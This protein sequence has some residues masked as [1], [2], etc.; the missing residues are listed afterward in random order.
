MIGL[1][2]VPVRRLGS[3]HLAVLQRSGSM[4]LVRGNDLRAD[5]CGLGEAFGH[6][7]AQ[8]VDLLECAMHI[9]KQRRHRQNTADLA[10]ENRLNGK[11]TAG[12]LDAERTA[13]VDLIGRRCI[14]RQGR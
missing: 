7:A 13:P 12:G 9:G 5:L 3:L 14:G 2:H 11:A 1:G 10:H 4:R 8:A 6:E